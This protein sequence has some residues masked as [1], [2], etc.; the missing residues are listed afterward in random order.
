M[1]ISLIFKMVKAKFN[2]KC[3]CILIIAELSTDNLKK[4]WFLFYV[5][6]GKFNKTVL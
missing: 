2:E 1:F 4:I 3:N 6:L 5:F